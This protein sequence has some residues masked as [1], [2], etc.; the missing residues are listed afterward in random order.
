M[1]NHNFPSVLHS[2]FAFWHVSSTFFTQ[3]SSETL[4][5]RTIWI[6][7]PCLPPYSSWN[8]LQSSCDPHKDKCKKMDGLMDEY[9]SLCGSPHQWRVEATVGGVTGDIQG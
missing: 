9:C 2:Q 5:I 4:I 1:M 7:L 6:L 3:Q 8:R